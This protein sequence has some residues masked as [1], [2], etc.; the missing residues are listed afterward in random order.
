MGYPMCTQLRAKLSSSTQLHIYD[1]N[2]TVLQKFLQDHNPNNNT[3]IGESPRDVAEK[4]ELIITILPEGSHVKSVYFTPETGILSS[5]QLSNRIFID[6]STIDTTS[7][8]IVGNAVSKANLGTFIDAPVSGGTIGAE[9]GT[10]T[11][12][13]GL[14]ENYPQYHHQILPVLKTMGKNFSACGA[15]T[16]GLITKLANNYLSGVNAIATS[17][18]MNFAVLHGADPFILQRAISVSS[19][20]NFI[21][22]VMNPVPGIHPNAPPS[23]GYKGGLKCS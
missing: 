14:P 3:F 8:K 18:A 10:L 12:M 4:S 15:P 16:L 23:K 11:F 5:F 20:R 19:G 13:I 2:T 21:N 7:S 1:L 17:E 9:A 22:D 6:C